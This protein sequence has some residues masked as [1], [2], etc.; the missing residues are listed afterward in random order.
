MSERTN[1]L[2]TIA[3]V[4]ADA[5]DEIHSV[6]I[7]MLHEEEG[8][9]PVEE[10][11]VDPKPDPEI[12]PTGYTPD[13]TWQAEGLTVTFSGRN[14]ALPPRETHTDWDF[15]DGTSDTSGGKFPA[16]TYAKAGTYAVTMHQVNVAGQIDGT[17]TKD[18]TVT[19]VATEPPDE[20]EPEEDPDPDPEAPPEPPI[21]PDPNIPIPPLPTG[22]KEPAGYRVLTDRHF[23]SK[24]TKAGKYPT[25]AE[26][27]K[28]EG[29]S[30]T[31]AN[32]GNFRIV[33]DPTAPSGDGL[34][35][36]MLYPAGMLAGR[37]PATATIY[38][39]HGITEAYVAY[40]FKYSPNWV[41][42]KALVNKTFFMGVSGGNNQLIFV[43]RGSGAPGLR[44]DD[45]TG[46]LVKDPS[47]RGTMRPI[48]GLQGILDVHDNN[49]INAARSHNRMAMDPSLEVVR[50]QWHKLELIIK[51]NS[52]PNKPDGRLMGWFDDTPA[53]DIQ[54]LNWTKKS[55]PTRPF[56]LTAFNENPTYGGGGPAVP[57]DQ[58]LR[59]DRVY[60][61]GK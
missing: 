44:W 34:V 61:S 51:G 25:P 15:G 49:P 57:F 19:G 26:L 6:V 33:A 48:I 37:G 41:A 1:R 27:A 12:P 28:G 20:E 3:S 55:E 24:V 45:A 47:W 16:H 58:W 23:R 38:F 31:E 50:D 11:P 29:W 43:A 54:N 18:V 46:T 59:F 36:E 2:K 21:P 5:I 42:N 60:V 4:L 30:S 39:E 10:P 13:F 8:P 56:E 53:W 9:P 17:I 32:H 40:W 52:G 14:L 7:E 35:G 22:N